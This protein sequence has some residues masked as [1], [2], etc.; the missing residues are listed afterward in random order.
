MSITV[1][2]EE[3][4][5]PAPNPQ[6]GESFPDLL[7]LAQNVPVVL[8]QFTVFND[9]EQRLTY[10]SPSLEQ[11]FPV[12]RDVLLSDWQAVLQ[13]VL[14]HQAPVF[15]AT[16]DKV[17]QEKS[18]FYFQ[19]HVEFDTGGLKWFEFKANPRQTPAGWVWDGVVREISETK[20]AEQALK[21][22]VDSFG[23]DAGDDLLR[24]VP[25]FLAHRL[26]VPWVGVGRY[27]A[28]QD[29]L[30]DFFYHHC[31]HGDA[32][33]EYALAGT[34]CQ[35]VVAEEHLLVADGVQAV[36]PQVDFLRQFDFRG[37]E[38]QAIV[39]SRGQV[40]GVLCLLS[41]KPLS[42]SDSRENLLRVLAA[43]LGAEM[44]RI[45]AEATLRDSESRFRTLVENVPGV[46]YRCAN[47][48]HWTVHFLSES[49]LD[50]VGYPPTDFMGNAVRSFESVIYPEDREQVRVGVQNGVDARSPYELNYRVMHRDGSIRWV[51]EKGQGVFDGKGNLLWLDG[52]IVDITA[53]H[54]AEEALTNAQ[55]LESLGVLA[56]GIAHDFN[57][58]LVAVLGNVELALNRLSQNPDQAKDFLKKSGQAATRASELCR[59]LLDYAGQSPFS[60][61]PVDLNGALLEMSEL[62]HTAL[63]QKCP[64]AFDLKGGLPAVLADPTQLRQVA[65][66]LMVN[67][68]EAMGERDGQVKVATG[69]MRPTPEFL[70]AAITGQHLPD[71]EYVFL[72]VAD[73][74]AG[75][76]PLTQK[77][78]FDPFF[79]TK[80]QGR[81][82]GLA[83]TL[84]I[85]RRHGGALHLKSVRNVGSV[86]RVLLPKSEKPAEKKAAPEVQTVPVGKG[87]LLVVDDDPTVCEVAQDSLQMVGFSVITAHNGLAACDLVRNRGKELAG[88][89]LDMNM[90]VMGGEEAYQRIR[91]SHPALPVVLTSGYHQHQAMKHLPDDPALDFLAKP[92]TPSRLQNAMHRLMSRQAA[93]TA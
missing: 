43:R 63:Q 53:T 25:E 24:H 47:D 23:A 51:S 65:L 37:Y 90:P 64:V 68:A 52:V 40:M 75:M 45:R 22:M 30:C 78:I 28:E 44:E 21:D 50:L 17:I 35:R 85:V 69:L 61:R 79:T 38:G 67:A 36:F 33:T 2:H 1:N 8:Y 12:S 82:L 77:R 83:A 32:S 88:V 86:F 11:L 71:G 41:D 29:K 93:P 42:A 15:L 5:G 14:P 26:G 9:G 84:G 76:D 7:A 49:I 10:I 4:S 81:G 34:P 89:L 70:A 87:M 73:E 46:I 31:G 59:Q 39:D 18:P 72:E 66:N 55:K 91:A 19:G 56:G 3:T 92:F 74:G 27:V 54:Q 57:N 48:E 16:L 60:T 58:I 80:A 62:L 6:E 13:S 20:K